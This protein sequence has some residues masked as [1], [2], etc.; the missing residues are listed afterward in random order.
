[1]NQHPQTE[2]SPTQPHDTNVQRTN[3]RRTKIWRWTQRLIAPTALLVALLMATGLVALLDSGRVAHAAPFG[4]SQTDTRYVSPSGSA[5][6]NCLRVQANPPATTSHAYPA[7]TLS[8]AIEVAQPGDT[9]RMAVGEYTEAVVIT[10]SLTILGGYP[11]NFA[12]GTNEPVASPAANI[13]RIT[14]NTTDPVIT[15]VGP[16][17]TTLT[18]TVLID[19]VRLLH[20]TNQNRAISITPPISPTLNGLRVRLDLTRSYVQNNTAPT[21]GGGIGVDARIIASIGIT[22]TEFNGNKAPTGGAISLSP[23]S[24]LVGSHARFLNN[25]ATAGNGGAVAVTGGIISLSSITMTANSATA[26]GGG[27]YALDTTLTLDGSVSNSSAGALGGGLYLTATASA[28]ASFSNLTLSNNTAASHGG[29][30]FAYNIALNIAGTG[31]INANSATG[32][33]GGALYLSGGTATLGP[34]PI[35]NNVAKVHGGGIYRENG[36]LILSGNKVMTNTATTGSG[37]GIAFTGNKVANLSG[38][39]LINN[40]AG[41]AGGGAAFVGASDITLTG[42][43]AILNNRAM[44]GNGGGVYITSIGS[45]ILTNNVLVRGNAAN[46]TGN[47]GAFYVAAPNA[48]LSGNTILINTA[49]AGGG[50]YLSSASSGLLADN[51]I[52]F[53]RATSGSGGGLYVV[54]SDNIALNEQTTLA[55]NQAQLHGGGLYAEQSQLSAGGAITLTTN[56]ATTGNGGGL[57]LAAGAGMTVTDAS[58]ISN[59]AQLNGGGLYADQSVFTASSTSAISNTALSGSGGAL[60]FNKSDLV[61]L[62]ETMLTSNRADDNGGAIFAT[63]SKITGTNLTA[64]RN[65]AMTASGGTIYVQASTITWNGNSST[66]YNQAATNGGAYFIS[67]GGVNVT[68]DASVISNTV[69]TGSGGGLYLDSSAALTVTGA[70][71]LQD[72][73]AQVNGGGL[74]VSEGTLALDGTGIV[75]GNRAT[76]GSGGAFYLVGV[77]RGNFKDLTFQSNHAQQNGGAIGVLASYLAFSGT[78]QVISNTATAGDGGG[79]YLTE[80]SEADFASLA[81][82]GNVANGNGGGIYATDITLA[83]GNGSVIEENQA[84]NGSGGGVYI[85][86]GEMTTAQISFLRNKAKLNGGALYAPSGPL[87]LANASIVQLNE[88]Q[89]GNGGGIYAGDG[90]VTLTGV[91][92]EQNFAQLNGGGLY[93]TSTT[94]SLLVQGNSTIH[95]NKSTTGKGGGL[96]VTGGAV[97][98]NSSSVTSNEANQGGGGLYQTGGTLTVTTNSQISANRTVTSSGGGLAVITGTVII[99]GSAVSQNSAYKDGGGLYAPGGQVSINNSDFKGNVLSLGRGGAIYVDGP[100]I[101]INGSELAD[102]VAVAGGGGLYARALFIRVANS[103]LL[104]NN[105]GKGTGGA[106]FLRA[107]QLDLFLNTIDDNET[108]GSGAG[109]AI[110]DTPASTIIS[111]TVTNNILRRDVTVYTHYVDEPIIMEGRTIVPVGEV[112]GEEVTEA[113]GAGFYFQRSKGDFTGNTLLH[114]ENK[115]GEGGGIYI[116]SSTITMTNNVVAQNSIALSDVYGS[117][118]Y[119]INSVVAMR[120]ST[121]ADNLNKST[122]AG[123]MSVG[124]YVTKSQSE[125]STINLTNNIIAGHQSGVMLLTGSTGALFN[126]LFFNSDSDWDSPVEYQPSVGNRVGDPLF[127]D[128]DNDNYDIQRKSAAFDMGT[129][130]GVA[131]DFRG[132]PRPRAFGVDA[133]AYEHRYL[134]GVHMRVTASPPFVGSGETIQYQVQVINHSPGPLSNVAVNFVLPSQQTVSSIIGPGCSGTSCSLGTMNADGTANITLVATANGTPPDQGFIE[135]L[136][137]VNVSVG[138]TGSSDTTETITTRLQRC[139]V[140]YN[141]TDFP[142]IQAAINAVNTLDD[143]PDTVRVSGYCGGSFEVT[144]KVTIQGGWNFSMT[145]HNLTQFPTTIDGGGSGRVVKITGEHA[146]VIQDLIL[147]NGNASGLG[148]GPSGKDAGGI[149][150]I[151][152]A[153]ATL[154]N[155]RMVG[156]RATFGAGLYVDRLSAPI[157]RNSI[158]ENGQASER[159]GG[160]YAH[161]S[162][163][164]LTNVTIRNNTAQAGGG[165]YLYKSEAKIVSC[166][167]SDNRATGSGSYLQVAG[168]NIRFSVGGGGG[169]NFDESKASIASSTLENNKAK[170]GG[171]VFADNSPGAVTSSLLNNNEANGSPVV[172]PIVILANTVGGGGAIYAQRSDMVIEYN[173]ITNNRSTSGPGGAIHIFNGTASGKINGNFLGYNSA[174]KGGAIYVHLKPD[175]VKIFV[176]PFTI[177][178]FIIPIILGKPQPDPPKLTMINNTIAHNGGSSAVHFYGE[179]YG[180]LVGNIFAFNSGTGVVAET[181]VLPYIM[182]IPVPI[183][184]VLPLPFPV[185]YVPKVDMNYT[186][187]HQNGGN[188]SGSGV[189]ASVSNQNSLTGD[190]AFKND[191]YHIK[192]ISAAYNTG[193]NTGI[194]V[195]LDSQPHPQG[196]ITDMGADEY[197]AIGVRYVAPGGGDSGGEFCRNYLN[198]CGSL[199]VAIDN[200]REGDLI[201]MAGGTYSGTDTRRNQVQMGYI[202][203]T[204][205]IQGGYYRYTTD[206]SV[207]EGVYTA[208]DWEVPFPD[209]NPT[210]LDAGGAGRIFYILDEKLL[211]DEGNPI[212]VEPTISGVTIQNGNSNG[213]KGPQGNEYDAGGAI[214]L[215]NT[216]ATI[217]NVDILNSRADYGGGVYMISSTL[218]LEDV[219]VRNNTA[220]FRGGGFYLETS[221][222]V[223]ISHIVIE[224]NKAPLGGGIYLEK[225][226]ARILSNQINSNGDSST[227]VAGGGIYLD[228]SSAQVISNTITANNAAN[229]AGFYAINSDANINGNTITNNKALNNTPDNGRG[230]GCY[231]GPGSTNIISN[232][233][234]GNQAIYGAGCYLNDTGSQFRLNQFLAN[235][236]TKSGGGLYASNST[237]ALIQENLINGNQASSTDAD[238]GGGGIFLESSSLTARFNT[239]TNN[240]ANAGGGAYLASFSNAT[241]EENDLSHNNATQD[242]AG[243]YLRLSDGQLAKNTITFNIAAQGNGAGVYIRL[244]NAQLR[245]NTIEENQATQGGGGVYLDQ[246]GASLESDSIR[247]NSAKD[248]AGLYVFRSDTAKFNKVA[249][250]NNRATQFGGGLYVR[251]SAVPLEDHVITE[252]FAQIAGGGIYIDESAISFNRNIIRNNEA[253][254]QGGGIAITRR[255]QAQLGSNAVVDNR[256]GTTGSGI[257]VSG[258]QP[259]LIHTT[260]ARNHGGDGSGVAAVQQEGS[261]STVT[262]VNTIFANQS[263][264]VKATVG[265]TITLQAT[266]WDSNG[267]NWS[268]GVGAGTIITG[269]ASLNFFGEARFQ[270]DGIH[271]QNNSKAIGVG[272]PSNVGRDVDGDGRPQGNGPEL[273]ADELLADCA[274]VVSTNLSVV[275]TSVQAAIDAAPPSAEVRISGTCVGA[276]TRAGTSQLAY[277][278]K[279]ITLRGG[280]TPTNWLLSYPITQPTFLDAQGAGRVIFVTPNTK[281]TIE[282][283]NLANGDAANQGGGPGGLDAGGILYVRNANPILRGLKITGGNAYYGG[284]LYLENSTTTLSA[285]TF[286]INKA[287]KGGGIFLRNVQATLLGNTINSNTATD[288]AGIF[289]SFSQPTLESNSLSLN[290]ATAAGGGFFLESSSATLRGNNILTNTAQTAGGIYIDGAN[291]SLL[292]NL[293][294]GNVGQNAGGIY[295]ATS[296]AIVNGNQVMANSAGIGAGIYVQAGNPTLDNNIVAKNIAQIQAAAFYILSSSPKLRHNTVAANNGGD[297]SALFVTDLGVQPANIEMVNNILVD[298]TVGIT[299][300]AGN[301]VTIRRGLLFNNGRDWG[302]DG[303]VDDKGGHVRAAPLF[304]DPDGNDY[305]LQSASPARD[306]G[307]SDAGINIDYDNQSRPADN[308]FDIGADEFVFTGVQVFIQTVP[309]PVVGGAPFALI[310]RVENSGNIEQTANIT[311]TLPAGMTPTGVLSWQAIIGRGETWVQTVNATV[312]PNFSGTLKLTVDVTTSANASESIEASINVSRPDY[313][314]AL[315]AEAMP[316]PVP[317]GGQL[318]YQIRLSNVGNQPLNPT[319]EAILPDTVSAAAPMSFSPG[320]LG[321][322]GAWT[323]TVNT[324]VSPDAK[325]NLTATFRVTTVE[326]P[327]ANYELTVPIAEP[328]LQTSLSATPDPVLAGRTVTYT[329]RVT[330]TGN[331]NFTNLIT[332]VAPVDSTGHPLV[333]PGADQTFAAVAIPAGGS[334]VQELVL[335]VEPGYTGPLDSQVIIATDTGLVTTHNDTRQV[336]LPTRGPTITAARSGPWNDP[337]TWEP[338]RVPDASDIALVPSGVSVTVDGRNTNPVVMTGLINQ[339]TIMLNCVSGVPMELQITEFIN[340]TG[341]I[342]GR[343]S[344]AIGEAGCSVTVQTNELTNN[345]PGIIRAGNGA[346]GGVVPPDNSGINGGDGGTLN[347]FLQSVV[348]SGQILAG[349]G[350]NLLAPAT[351]GRGGDGGNVLVAAG[352]P[353]P[354][355]LLNA[356]LIAAGDGGSGPGGDGRGGDGGSAALLSTG[357]YTNAG[358]EARG[359]RGGDGNGDGIGGGA[360]DGTDGGAS[361]TAAFT[362]DNGTR[363]ANN[364]NFAFSTLANSIVRG[365]AGAT[366]L[367]PITFLNEGIRTDTYLL[368]WSNSAG[369]TQNFL[370]ETQRIDGLRYGVLLTPFVI[371]VETPTGAESQLRLTARSQGDPSLLKEESVR[372]IVGV[373]GRTFLPT[374]HHN[375]NPDALSSQNEPEAAIPSARI[376]FL[377]IIVD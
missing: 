298:H 85:A 24:R 257:Y 370:P 111:N 201:K 341:L 281:A 322:G 358:G 105:G 211:D 102:N 196:D 375:S 227:T 98:I 237:D 99:S 83:F 160:V 18:T 32:G 92:I 137:T 156:G 337:N 213:L 46:G 38:I 309:D 12:T 93:L 44:N 17:T 122:T 301:K 233:F 64:Q 146:A 362:W 327:T 215:D 293:V 133:G 169:V 39:Y 3:V 232:L 239:I 254:Q 346:D 77:T 311:A 365:V 135:M 34:L 5:T 316:S 222:D 193:K 171:A 7:C 244:S 29:G 4:A 72:N 51:V 157:I 116:S 192:R 6:G 20:G 108:S 318:T 129:P 121:I 373:G 308:G 206:N 96:Y 224:L 235:T 267:Q 16:T 118:V 273:G 219:V 216:T 229:G 372:I 15:I 354:A 42:S 26:N 342:T 367:V 140:R 263:Q 97:T 175:T 143:L 139:R 276:Q 242:G 142:T 300:T 151:K 76:T 351:S 324:T 204:I 2:P 1:M 52:Q 103:E 251:L 294:S 305:H 159:G 158:I 95:Q 41:M 283:L 131:T 285:S 59:T 168:F 333:S 187:W 189:G 288:G 144:K 188:T 217:R 286:E 27:V 345:S 190:P 225:S 163:P 306:Q 119:I 148:G 128:P 302:G 61:T 126:N 125:T 284:G 241:L 256:A 266:L 50:V 173:R 186:L 279:E 223:A 53:N 23:G 304:V 37:G 243:V 48:T 106:A 326:G 331:I 49:A 291:P 161:N 74:Y 359:G 274:A 68:G 113:P 167:I 112:T 75:S 180:E 33:S 268:L 236:A 200:A 278:N 109:L 221:N 174:S 349:N 207:T 150:Y 89:T 36:D 90:E 86:N 303:I 55:N 312:D 63:E 247:N 195:D 191:G 258:S 120:H 35:T 371:P 252:N 357:Q 343:D 234:Q 355:L 350:G 376:N 210:I 264:G 269:V 282:H 155:V 265:S 335:L 104:S 8:R 297:G 238:N 299:L 320:P 226:N 250:Q 280:Y 172:I 199:Q 185:F 321:P 249:I 203:K 248:G 240:S 246:S 329:L 259:M 228:A 184:F 47:G 208:H 325:G 71:D 136:T 19:G 319:V 262:M 292:R 9:I 11:A 214:Y 369:W 202:T 332:F 183:I 110:E 317:A 56:R 70:F 220:N 339:G 260:I 45:V 181:Q 40:Q 164:E 245:E 138:S 336:I 30:I 170:A 340:N 43:P 347:V 275:Y 353:D 69:T 182:M 114:N 58:F 153:R 363:R 115:S 10:R 356:G 123:A 130:A 296:T 66:Q 101:T 344:Q 194:P 313:A 360:N 218:T 78:T 67:G 87:T 177:P 134:Q 261:F 14:V 13:T 147:R 60:Y 314:V 57:Y 361:T 212:K 73:V 295:L 364:R 152:D 197:P 165:V 141:N 107:D 178:D 209:T 62:G 88:A 231:V 54:N 79:L 289:L 124:I 22:N 253:G 330:N 230:G 270:A 82:R 277:V 198:P 154:D 348:N 272:V 338:A 145:S 287:I 374:L 166:N 149:V 25:Q 307:A 117:G 84:Q 368:V 377:P 94:T 255:S 205:T 366:V 310:V 315:V 290:S 162:S 100:N 80:T 323:K 132:T 334:W 179:S 21:S 28:P 352:P 328:G 271:L 31:P 81:L 65:R 127:V 176:I 91:Q